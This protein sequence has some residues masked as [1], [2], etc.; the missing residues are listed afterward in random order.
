MITEQ[1]TCLRTGNRIELNVRCE[2]S[3]WSFLV[4]LWP[5]DENVR[6]AA[7]AKTEQTPSTGTRVGIPSRRTVH[8]P[9]AR[10]LTPKLT[11]SRRRL[12]PT[13]IRNVYTRAANVLFDYY[14]CSTVSGSVYAAP[15]HEVTRTPCVRTLYVCVCVL[16]AACMTPVPAA[17][18]SPSAPHRSPQ[19]RETIPFFRS[20]TR[21]RR[22][23]K[24]YRV[25]RHATDTP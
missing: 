3:E 4:K 11:V 20:T 1:N 23:V 24:T 7:H 18:E 14:V 8:I 13:P 17:R 5:V 16:H 10:T 19:S 21:P 9:A 2:Q 15:G 25:L 12:R 22:L 6:A